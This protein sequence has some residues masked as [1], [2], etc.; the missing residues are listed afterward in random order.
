MKT[1]SMTAM[2]LLILVGANSASNAELHHDVFVGCVAEQNSNFLCENM[3]RSNY[4]HI[5]GHSNQKNPGRCPTND[6]PIAC[7]CDYSD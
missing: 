7:E 1:L 6:K 4:K 2:A 5:V 3:C